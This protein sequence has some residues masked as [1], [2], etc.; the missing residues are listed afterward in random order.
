MNYLYVSFKTF[1]EYYNKFKTDKLYKFYKIQTSK[2]IKEH[3]FIKLNEIFNKDYSD[4]EYE[5]YY[6]DNEITTIKFKTS[7]LNVYRLDLLKMKNY[8]KEIDDEFVYN[9]S[10]TDWY[11][12]VEKYEELTNKNEI[13]ELLSKIGFIL[14][15]YNKDK[16]QSYCIGLT[17]DDRKNNLYNYFLRIVFKDYKIRLDYCDGLINNKAIYIFK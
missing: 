9:I 1:E 5:V 15:D 12:D 16:N 17:L 10:F 8:C 13:Y 11:R 6:S 14:R 4:V 2:Y 7:N 3:P